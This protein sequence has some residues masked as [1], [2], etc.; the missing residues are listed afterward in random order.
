LLLK[1][2]GPRRT[3]KSIWGERA[4]DPGHKR[5]V[6]EQQRIGN[7]IADLGQVTMMGGREKGVGYWDGH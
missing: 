4:Q 7:G 2:G 6:P 5:G 3:K 1:G